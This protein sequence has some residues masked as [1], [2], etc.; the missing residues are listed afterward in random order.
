M[1]LQEYIDKY[2]GQGIDVDNAFGYQCVDNMHRYIQEVLGLT[3]LSIL[4]GPSAKDIY[5]SFP[6]IVGF[7]Y[8]NKIDNTPT[9]VPKPGD[10]MFWGT[11]VGKYGHVA[12]FKDGN[13]DSFISFDQN[14]PLGS[15][16]HLQPHNYNG[17]VGWLRPIVLEPT[18][19]SGGGDDMTLREQFKV[20]FSVLHSNPNPTEADVDQ[21]VGSALPPYEY[22]T[23]D[24]NSRIIQ[25]YVD[26]IKELE[27]EIK[28]LNQNLPGSSNEA[29][30]PA[31]TDGTGS[32]TPTVQDTVV[33][34][35]GTNNWRNTFPTIA[36]FIDW[37]LEKLRG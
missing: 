13:A 34:P 1:T 23:Q 33:V 24:L 12:I 22:G 28:T 4:A 16:C 21:A 20:I 15:V 27:N 29:G 30:Q 6:N 35:G 10:I 17:V 26:K 36:K 9:G 37:L 14:F 19:P 7:Q 2:N 5:N 32:G 11:K 31:E 25:P 8:F 3:N 18:P